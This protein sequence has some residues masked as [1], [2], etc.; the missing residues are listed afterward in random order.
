M[1]YRL[2]LS[3]AYAMSTL[4]L[5]DTHKSEWPTNLEYLNIEIDYPHSTSTPYVQAFAFKEVKFVQHLLN[6]VSLT[7][8]KVSKKF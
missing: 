7:Q 6:V 5:L 1:V 2:V 3:K 8:G 4:L